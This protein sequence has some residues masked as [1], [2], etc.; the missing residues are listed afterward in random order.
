MMP[1]NGMDGMFWRRGILRSWLSTAAVIA[2]AAG[3]CAP[4]SQPAPTPRVTLALVNGTLIDGTGGEP[5]SGAAVLIAG[6]RIVDVGPAARIKVPAGARTIDLGG[7]TILPGFINAHVHDA[8][9]E[10][11]LRAWAQGGVTTVRDEGAPV[12]QIDGLKSFQA[13]IGQDPHDARLVS[14]GTMLAVPGGYGDLFVSSPQEARQAVLDEYAKGVNAIKVALEDGYGGQHGLPKL[15]AEELRT[16]VDTAHAHGLRVSGHITQGIYL[17]PMLDA[18]VDDIAHLPY[19]FVPDESLKHMVEKGVYIVPTFTIFRNYGAPVYGCVA[20]LGQIV[21]LG[22]KVALGN[23]YGGGQGEFELGIPMYE[24]EMM[25]AAGMTPMQIIEAATRNGAHVVNLEDEIGTLEP[26]KAA[27]VLVV[28][29]D[30]L[31]DL[32]ALGDVRL[33]VHAGSVIRNEIS[34]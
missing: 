15:T 2:V 9:D 27:D 17:Q 5:V 23:D 24:I 30:P 6:D 14:S 25:S 12:A 10:A 28:G 34:D 31:A 33:V 32:H 7:A 21:Q 22:G 1:A 4:G 18:G 13:R 3:G 26:G 8:F 20:N 19:D 11:N 16:I 29:G